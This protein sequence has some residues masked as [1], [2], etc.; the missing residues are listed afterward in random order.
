MDSQ[1]FADLSQAQ[2]EQVSGGG[3]LI[4]LDDQLDTYF[5]AEK[6]LVGLKVGQTSGPEG[7]EIMQAFS[8]DFTAIDTGAEKD[9]FATFK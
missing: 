7:S 5:T 6:S 8:Q 4:D 9:F 3:Q 2:Q 1:L